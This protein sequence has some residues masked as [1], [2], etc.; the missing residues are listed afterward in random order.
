M[1]S[2]IL[3]HHLI[4]IELWY[5]DYETYYFVPY[6]T[7]HCWTWRS[8]LELLIIIALQEKFECVA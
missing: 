3:F 6:M 5:S 2:Y 8:K 4:T 1:E 7:C